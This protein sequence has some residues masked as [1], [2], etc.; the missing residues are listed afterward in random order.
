MREDKD[1]QPDPE[2]LT[3]PLQPFEESTKPRSIQF[4]IFRGPQDSF[5]GHLRTNSLTFVEASYLW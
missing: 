4:D 5:L 1:G 3:D 2:A